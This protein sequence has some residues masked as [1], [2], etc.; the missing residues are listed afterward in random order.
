MESAPNIAGAPLPQPARGYWKAHLSVGRERV[1]AFLERE[2]AQ[3]PPW[4]VVGFG[5]GIAAWFVLDTPTQWLAFLAIAGGIAVA[6]FT[7]RGGRA[8]RAVGWFAVALVL[9]C[10]LAWG[11][12]AWVAAPRLERPVIT[13]FE[14]RVERVESLVARGDVD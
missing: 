3:L 10:A 6:G 11:R 5:V 14:A 8:E 4:F 12:S 7:A 1:E 9:G 13:A 2:R